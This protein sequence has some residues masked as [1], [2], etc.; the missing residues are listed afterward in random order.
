MPSILKFLAAEEQPKAITR[1]TAGM[2]ASMNSQR[3][4][5]QIPIRVCWKPEGQRELTEETISLLVSPEGALIAL[6]M[7]VSVGSTFVLR[8]WELA[9]EQLCQVVRVTDMLDG[10]NEV[11][12]SFPSPN[13]SFWG[14][15]DSLF[16]SDHRFD[17]GLS[18]PRSATEF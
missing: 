9:N 13:P 1:K 11:E 3:V 12:V 15:E 5:K 10:E 18:G 2:L 4:L 8:K 6:A 14:L 7:R 17:D 16:S